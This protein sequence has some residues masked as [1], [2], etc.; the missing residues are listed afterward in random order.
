MDGIRAAIGVAP[1]LVLGALIAGYL[2]F[3]KGQQAGAPDE[4]EEAAL[5]ESDER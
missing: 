2:I 4:V 1:V 5:V 3:P